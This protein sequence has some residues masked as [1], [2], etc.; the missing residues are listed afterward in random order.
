MKRAVVLAVLLVLVAGALAFAQEM[1]KADPAQAL[2]EAVARGKVLFGDVSLG[3]N[4]MSCNS[5]HIEGG[6]KPGQM[7]DM[8][9]PPFAQVRR[10]YPAYFPM[11]GRVMTL[12]QVVNFCVTTPLEGKALPWDDQ[13]LADLAAYI[14]SVNAMMKQ[15]QGGQMGKGKGKGMGQGMDESMMEKGKKQ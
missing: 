7:G 1:K 4:G 2:D 14:T 5:C 9:I 8:N 15:G 12:D 10:K 3:T 13:R 11:A 6:T